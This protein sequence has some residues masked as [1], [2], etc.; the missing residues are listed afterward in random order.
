LRY[1]VALYF[2][3]TEYSSDE[4]PIEAE[5]FD[6]AFYNV[7]DMIKNKTVL[8]VDVQKNNWEKVVCYS[9]VNMGMVTKF[10]IFKS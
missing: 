3:N 6:E 7:A 5:N 1:T 9:A 10:D 8:V 4:I 2:S